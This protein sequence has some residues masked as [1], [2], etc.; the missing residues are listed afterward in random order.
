M[1]PDV[2]GIR[3][4]ANLFGYVRQNSLNNIDPT[5][6]TP[7]WQSIQYLPRETLNSL[8]NFA[9]RVPSAT[10][11]LAAVTALEMYQTTV[12]VNWGAAVTAQSAAVG[13]AGALG[14]YT[15]AWINERIDSY[16]G[17]GAG[18]AFYDIT[19]P[20]DNAQMGLTKPQTCPR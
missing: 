4:G 9:Q 7:P 13:A 15:G 19:H 11:A 3:G 10:A 12:F 6:L 20:D 17:Q 2:I 16:Y 14:W 18:G 8:V 1:S 5:G